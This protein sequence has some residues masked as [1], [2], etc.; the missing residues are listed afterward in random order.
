MEANKNNKLRTGISGLDSLFYGGIHLEPEV[1]AKPQAKAEKEYNSLLLLAR[2]RHGVNKVHLAMQMCEGLHNSI[3]NREELEENQ[4][5]DW[6]HLPSKDPSKE[7]SILFVSLNKDTERLRNTYIGFYIQR[8][9]NNVQIGRMAKDYFSTCITNFEWEID[10]HLDNEVKKI[11]ELNTETASKTIGE[12]VIDGIIDGSIFYD[13]RTQQ[14]H[15]KSP[16]SSSL[17]PSLYTLL[18]D[19]NDYKNK[20]DIRFIGC[21]DEAI[22]NEELKNDTLTSFNNMLNSL[23]KICEKEGGVN[24]KFN[25][26]M[27]DGLSRLTEEEIG[28]CRFS[29]LTNVMRKI[30]KIGIITADEKLQPTSVA[31][32]M[33]ID[34]EIREEHNP[35]CQQHVLKVSKCLYQDHVYGWH[36]YKMRRIGIEVI[37]SLHFQM[38]SRF[39]MDDA[40]YYASLGLDEVPCDYFIS[41]YETNKD[42]STIWN[43][44]Y[45]KKN[46]GIL[47]TSLGKG[48]LF[49]INVDRQD[50]GKYLFNKLNGLLDEDWNNSSVLFIDLSRNRKEFYD[51]YE[52]IINEFQNIKFYSK[53][54]IHLFNF[55]PGFIHDD[56]FL[57]SIEKQIQAIVRR[58][59]EGLDDDNIKKYYNSV[60]LVIGDINYINF[61][62]PCLNRDGL[63]LPAISNFTKKH[64]MTNFIYTSA[65][66]E[67]SILDKEKDL[68]QQLKVVS[69]MLF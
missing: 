65:S 52:T 30:C 56:D 69:K 8:L 47:F 22:H 6:I 66:W 54:K 10:K 36:C 23:L 58:D 13:A 37:P 20:I 60:H 67:I 28:K 15:L 25:C 64:H 31:V 29:D 68:Y 21:H 50:N 7:K 49:A 39:H 32:D 19:N 16:N 5:M 33:V 26:L 11:L 4:Q 14:L 45:E 48:E 62:Y 51:N 1:N 43:E 3:R 41:E 18:V 57:Y 35:D 27:I 24:H 40:A 38:N 55:R 46:K 44:Y 61:A 42:V 17:P 59:H 12:K 63:L 53:D 9:I 2:G 34:M